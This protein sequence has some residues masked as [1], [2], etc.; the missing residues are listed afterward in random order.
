MGAELDGRRS[1]KRD[2]ISEVI[3]NFGNTQKQ[4]YLRSEIEST[5]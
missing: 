2:L 4:E 3:N 5:T 1:E